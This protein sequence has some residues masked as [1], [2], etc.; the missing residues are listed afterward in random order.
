VI[1]A[2]RR[3]AP[4]ASVRRAAVLWLAVAILCANAAGCARADP[5]PH[6]TLA[7]G[8]EPLRT[9]FNRDTGKPRIVIVAAPT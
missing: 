4:S 6:E 7:A 1:E 3:A 2:P 8:A 5:R 9:A